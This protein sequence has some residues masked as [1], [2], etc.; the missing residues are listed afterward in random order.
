[1]LPQKAVDQF[2]KIFT[3][4]FGQGLNDNEASFRANNLFELYR[5][6]YNQSAIKNNQKNE[7]E[8]DLPI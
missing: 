2:K 1:M 8:K 4:K 3:E 5:A 6:V 7:N